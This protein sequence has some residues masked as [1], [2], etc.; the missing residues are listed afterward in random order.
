MICLALKMSTEALPAASTGNRPNDRTDPGGAI[1][2][3]FPV[4]FHLSGGLSPAVLN[5]ESGWVLCIVGL[6]GVELRTN[7][8]FR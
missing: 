7:Q 3:R 5:E 8:R 6:G 1:T 2:L 4:A